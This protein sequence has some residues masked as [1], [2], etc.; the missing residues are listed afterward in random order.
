M[1]VYR[2]CVYLLILWNG[3]GYECVFWSCSWC[4]RVCLP[5]CVYHEYIVHIHRYMNV[6]DFSEAYAKSWFREHTYATTPSS[7]ISTQREII[8]KCQRVPTKC[9]QCDKLHT[10]FVVGSLEFF[11]LCAH[12]ESEHR[13]YNRS[14]WKVC[15][16]SVNFSDISP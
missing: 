13:M 15:H 1:N 4:V 5:A 6:N 12:G 16:C 2:N 14:L 11:S 10:A 9:E 7:T 8:L 3:E